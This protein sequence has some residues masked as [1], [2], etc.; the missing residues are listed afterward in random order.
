MKRF[1]RIAELSK[2]SPGKVRFNSH[3]KEKGAKPKLRALD[4][5]PS[6]CLFA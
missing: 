1:Q 4:R 3:R 5:K 6:M 2:L